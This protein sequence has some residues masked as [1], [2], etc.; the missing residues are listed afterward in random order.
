MGSD[1]NHITTNAVTLGPTLTGEMR[2]YPCC[3]LI[4]D[5]VT[6]AEAKEKLDTQHRLCLLMKPTTEIERVVVAHLASADRGRDSR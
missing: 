1:E 2:G 6:A 5:K 3:M 4:G